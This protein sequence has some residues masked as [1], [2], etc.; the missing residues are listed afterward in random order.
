MFK[1]P[2]QINQNII[3]NGCLQVIFL[4][5]GYTAQEQRKPIKT[6]TE[7]L[8][9]I[10]V[11]D[12]ELNINVFNQ[13]CTLKAGDLFFCSRSTY[14]E[15]HTNNDAFSFV[16]LRFLKDKLP[17]NVIENRFAASLLEN[18]IIKQKVFNH[19]L[20][21]VSYFEQ[22]PN[23]LN[24]SDARFLHQDNIE[25]LSILSIMM[26][27]RYHQSLKI[28]ENKIA[29]MDLLVEAI[30][31]LE[32]NVDKKPKIND[33]VGELGV[34]HSYFVRVFK[35]YVG[36]TPNT[37]MQTLRVNYSLSIISQKMGSLCEVSYLLGFSDQSH[38]NNVFKQ[39]LQLTPGDALAPRS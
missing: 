27:D 11:F 39:H 13:I 4:N 21:Y 34:S 3:T 17:D 30:D 35:R 31:L 22:S 8:D 23:T 33:I 2:S 10:I 19:C 12:G 38:F 37:F 20:S 36:A 18:D 5:G 15:I 25:I 28:V 29:T 16:R 7:H 14:S 24:E 6:Y 32:I 1:I 26:G 9:I